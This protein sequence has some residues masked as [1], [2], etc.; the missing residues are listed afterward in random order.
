MAARKGIDRLASLY[1][2]MEQI[3]SVELRAA[4]IAVED[5]ACSTTIALTLRE[6]Q[7][8]SA[9]EA[10]ATGRREEWQISETA[11]VAVEARIDQLAKTRTDRE[12]ARAEAH[13]IHRQS[14]LDMEQMERVVAQ[15]RVQVAIE[16]TRRTQ[17]ESD[18]RFASRRAWSRTRRIMNSE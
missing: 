14:R 15:A 10:M 11:R 17:A 12:N 5:A 2:M 1:G 4:T 16:V 18:D 9:R 6:S 13:Q 8:A 3:R 7:I